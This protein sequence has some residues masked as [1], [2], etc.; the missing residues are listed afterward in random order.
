MENGKPVAQVRA[1][2]IQTLRR[3]AD[4][5]N[6]LGATVELLLLS[7]Q[8]QHTSSQ[9]HPMHAVARAQD[10]R[11]L[12]EYD[13]TVVAGHGGDTHAEVEAAIDHL[14]ARE[15]LPSFV[16]SVSSEDHV[17]RIKRLWSRLREPADDRSYLT[18]VVGT[19][20][21][22]AANN[23]LPLILESGQYKAVVPP[24]EGVF[25]IDSRHHEALATELQQVIDSYR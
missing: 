4:S 12:D 24:L 9:A 25:D 19:G 7:G 22:Y 14:D 3:V 21:T 6:E 17:A 11:L 23:Q 18:T 20:T 13:S 15:S 10:E 8:A 5:Y 1:N 2:R 16:V